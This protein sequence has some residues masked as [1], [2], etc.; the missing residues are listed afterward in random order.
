MEYSSE[1][2]KKI[3][4]QENGLDEAKYIDPLIR[5]WSVV[6]QNLEEEFQ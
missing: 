1:Q 4:T 3:P 6:Y 5:I 2:N